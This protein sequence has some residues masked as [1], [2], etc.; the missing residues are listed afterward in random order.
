M[1]YKLAE[2]II[3]KSDIAKLKGWLSH[4]RQLT[5]GALTWEFEKKWADW[6]GTKYAVFCNSG[7]SA[8]LLAAYALNLSG[9]LKNNTVIVPSVGWVTTISPFMQLGFDPIMCG[10]DKDNLGLD[11][12]Q[13]EALLKRHN[14]G[15]VVV[16]QVLGVPM[17]MERTPRGKSLP[18]PWLLSIKSK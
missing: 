1:K 5:K 2:S 16:V 17:N 7:S 11:L 9:K 6:I 18:Q 4:D 14:P 10:A 3:D 12:G 13:L 15:T 8:N